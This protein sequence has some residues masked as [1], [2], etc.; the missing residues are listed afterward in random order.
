MSPRACLSIRSA[1]FAARLLLLASM[2]VFAGCAALPNPLARPYASAIRGTESTPLGKVATASAPSD[3]LSGFRLLPNGSFALNARLELV[4]RAASSIDLQYYLV[5]ND[6]AGRTLLAALRDAANRGVR[7]RLL[8]DDLY[9][10]DTDELLTGLAAYPNV[11]IRMFNP[12]AG[13]RRNLFTRLVTSIGDL[14]R[15]NRRMHNKMM[16]ADGAFAIAGGR[17]VAD[18]YFN[19]GRAGNFVDDDLLVAGP[20]VA[21]L[22]DIFDLYWNSSFVYSIQELEP[23]AYSKAERDRFDAL[24]EPIGPVYSA[25]TP[26]RDVLGFGPIGPELDQGRLDLIQAISDV[27]ADY[28]SKISTPHNAHLNSAASDVVS[29][30]HAAHSD[31]VISSPYFVPGKRGMSLLADDQKRGIRINLLTNSLSSNDSLLA[32]VGYARYRVGILKLGVDLYELS[33]EPFK[34]LKGFGNFRSIGGGLHAKQAVID[35]ET[36][37]VGSMNLDARSEDQNTE[38]GIVVISRE[39]SRQLL[40]VIELAE[41]ESAYRLRLDET[42]K[43]EWLRTDARG[44][45]ILTTQPESS[46]W[47]RFAE[48]ILGPI[49]PEE[50]L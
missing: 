10:A 39:L 36:L 33:A 4:R 16:I 50:E 44:Q 17:N 47:E 25:G 12:F 27:Y 24:V 43:V 35:S 21:K 5:A 19:V 38:L 23:G 13:N 6:G 1:H 41:L 8:V 2:A 40:D 37:F 42:G 30:M 29:I 32:D 11:Q 49:T 46:P 20:L 18:E 14:P 48:W 45:S 31:L 22:S 26:A 7:V 9:T 28:P 15:I 3:R 34:E